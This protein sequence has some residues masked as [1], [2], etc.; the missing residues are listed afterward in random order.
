[1]KLSL[2]VTLLKLHMWLCLNIIHVQTETGMHKTV[3][4]QAAVK[5]VVAWRLLM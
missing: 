3:V 4:R 2:V 5:K 1:M